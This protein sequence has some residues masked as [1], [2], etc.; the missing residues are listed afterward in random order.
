MSGQTSSGISQLVG[1]SCGSALFL[2]MITLLSSRRVIGKVQ[3][4]EIDSK[5]GGI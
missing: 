1:G 5:S 4:F 2:P 3:P